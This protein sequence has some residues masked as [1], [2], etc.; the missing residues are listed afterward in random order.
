M[1]NKVQRR[2]AAAIKDLRGGD[3]LLYWAGW[4]PWRCLSRRTIYSHAAMLAQGRE[5]PN[6]WQVLE[7]RTRGGSVSLLATQVDRWPGRIDVFQ[8]NPGRRWATFNRNLAVSVMRGFTQTHYSRFNLFCA[9]CCRLPIVWRLEKAD[10][11]NLWPWWPL[12]SSHA[13]AAACRA[14]GVDPVALLGDR[15]TEPGD[16]AWSSFFKYR[17]T[18]VP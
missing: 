10:T 1:Q 12:P 18:L 17:F 15:L 14:G 6:Q 4:R 7:M 8:A 9:A 16:L 11:M 5:W 3:L 2:F 13:I